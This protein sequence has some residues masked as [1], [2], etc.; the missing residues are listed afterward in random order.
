[1]AT[2]IRRHA[3]P[4]LYLEEWIAFRGLNPATL[5]GR[6]DM[7]RTTVWRWVKEQHRLNPEKMAHLAA[8]LDVETEELFRPPPRRSIDSMLKGQSD[9]IQ[10]MAADIIS[11]LI[12]RAS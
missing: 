2:R 10:D 12:K 11:R 4:H 1:M 5:A 3:R 8:A 7:D 6:M 9:D